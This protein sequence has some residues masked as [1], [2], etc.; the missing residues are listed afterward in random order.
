MATVLYSTGTV[1]REIEIDCFDGHEVS[2]V[3]PEGVTSVADA[4]IEFRQGAS[5]G[6]TNIET[7]P[8]DLSPFAG[9]RSMFQIR[10]TAGAITSPLSRAWQL[11]VGPAL[12]EVAEPFA[13]TFL[14]SNVEFLGEVVTFNQ[15]DDLLFLTDEITFLSDPVT[16]AP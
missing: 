15:D 9:T 12:P 14:A 7:T 4:A 3:Y 10:Q 11:R 1:T 2:I 8:F 16:Y 5:G 13:V 6:W